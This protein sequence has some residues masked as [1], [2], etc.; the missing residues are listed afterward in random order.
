MIT[1]RQE[2]DANQRKCSQLLTITPSLM[3]LY[4][5]SRNAVAF[6]KPTA[7]TCYRNL[8]ALENSELC[9]VAVY[10]T[11]VTTLRVRRPLLEHQ[12]ISFF[13]LARVS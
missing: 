4:K 3:Q 12:Q 7:M 11:N 9:V 6:A 10:F 2:K 13:S 8:G 1:S 5:R